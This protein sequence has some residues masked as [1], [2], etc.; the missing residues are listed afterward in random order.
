MNRVTMITYVMTGILAVLI[1][2]YCC[3]TDQKEYTEY[4]SGDDDISGV[5]L[6][7]DG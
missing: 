3:R 5:Q 1:I 7:L 4:F 6:Y 2:G